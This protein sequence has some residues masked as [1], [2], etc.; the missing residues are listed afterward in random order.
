MLMG[1][2]AVDFVLPAIGVLLGIGLIVMLFKYEDEQREERI[3][4]KRRISKE[5]DKAYIDGYWA[6]RRL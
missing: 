4:L 6:G 2:F 3:R 5:R 1:M